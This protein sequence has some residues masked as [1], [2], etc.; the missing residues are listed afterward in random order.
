MCAV[1][2]TDA[3][4]VLSL[5]S[6]NKLFCC[7]LSLRRSEHGCERAAGKSLLLRRNF[8]A[9]GSG[10]GSD[11]C[12]DHFG[13]AKKQQTSRV[14]GTI[15]R[16][17]GSRGG[18]GCCSGS[19]SFSGSS[20]KRKRRVDQSNKN[21]ITCRGAAVDGAG[22]SCPK[23]KYIC[24]V[25]YDGTRYNGFQLQRQ[26]PTIQGKL[27]MCLER[28]LGKDRDFLLVQGA[29]RT[30]SGV[31]AKQQ[32][33]QFFSG[34]H[35]EKEKFLTCMNRMLPEDI[36]VYGLQS[37]DGDFNVRYSY[38]KIYSYDIHLGTLR[39]PML[40]RY[41]HH[42]TD[43][44]DLDVDKMGD[45]L[46]E[47]CGSHD[48]KLLHNKSADGRKMRSSKRT[49]YSFQMEEI[50][51]GV[52]Y[53]CFGNGF[54]YKQ[55]RHMMG[56]IL[57]VGYGYLDRDDVQNLIKGQGEL[58]RTKCLYKV[59]EG[60]GLTLQKVFLTRPTPEELGLLL[61]HSQHHSS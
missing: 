18:C 8:S 34:R 53:S 27:E 28:Y 43:L 55:M 32:V 39:D 12:G 48:F 59:A 26:V 29:A 2:Y 19:S 31:H 4:H 33:I 44:E 1:Q 37:V 54:L 30:D 35:L 46:A 41:R 25:A 5:T 57:A 51:D 17:A 60:K 9:V 50:P 20:S 6:K 13:A 52:R 47:F 22:E 23:Y 7:N 56:V 15:I 40:A 49:I 14:T 3:S 24:C 61:Q 36:V 10:V 16:Q 38:G 45:I 42:P 58:Q 11:G 21:R